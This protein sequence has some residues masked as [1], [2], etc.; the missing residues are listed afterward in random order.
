MSKRIATAAY[1][2]IRA[3]IY[4]ALSLAIDSEPRR[5]CEASSIQIPNPTPTCSPRAI[6]HTRESG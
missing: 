5:R 1:H 6:D 2:M 3:N 4:L